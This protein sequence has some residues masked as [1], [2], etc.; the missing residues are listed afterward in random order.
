M[1]DSRAPE[2]TLAVV[3][4]N[5]KEFRN[6]MIS[7]DDNVALEKENSQI[8]NIVTLTAKTVVFESAIMKV[9][10]YLPSV[11]VLKS[12]YANEPESL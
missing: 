12:V 5:M 8:N 7:I 9:K 4:K 2:N 11:D 3:P 1:V 6:K 10:E